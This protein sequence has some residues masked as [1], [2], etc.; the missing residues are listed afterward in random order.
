[1]LYF[2]ADCTLQVVRTLALFLALHATVPVSLLFHLPE[3]TKRRFEGFKYSIT[4]YLV[5]YRKIF[6][7]IFLKGYMCK[8]IG[9]L[10]L[11]YYY[12]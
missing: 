11:C 4:L 6:S 3:L 12:H 5:A 1:M 7:K 10:I 8:P 2:P 9:I